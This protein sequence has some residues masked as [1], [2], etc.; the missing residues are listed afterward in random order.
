M[1]VLVYSIKD[2]E[3]PYLREAN[4]YGHQLDYVAKPLSLES[5][6]LAKGY[7]CISIFTADDAS[8]PVIK[9]LHKNGVKYIALRAA[10]F[11]NVDIEAANANGITVANVPSYSPHAIAEHAAAL[12]LALN[13]KIVRADK[14]VHQQNFTLDDLIGFDLNGKT[15]GIIGT[16]KIGSVMAKIMHGF[17]CS[18]LAYD[19]VK[20][21]KLISHYDVHYVSLDTLLCKS[22]IV[23]IHTSLNDQTKH[24]IS[25]PELSKMKEGVLLINTSRGAI[26]RTEDVIKYLEL[27]RIGGL[28]MD[29]YEKEKG[30]FFFDHSGEDLKDP[31][32]SKL[33]SLPNVLLTPHQAFGTKEALG[34]IAG[35]TLYNIDSW[36]KNTPSL[37]ELTLR[38][39]IS[40]LF[41]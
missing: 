25:E 13:R 19:V 17:G 29:V 28:G 9:N 40:Q 2:F 5:A 23:T 15:A 7:D 30:L 3:K 1:K 36:Q 32:L 38:K 39:P 31:M 26:V 21:Q 16:G 14:K 37:N 41:G 35:T 10:G 6:N 4:V 24:L 34:N 22:D 33:L 8:A 18:I 12:I 27:G 11:D 20:D